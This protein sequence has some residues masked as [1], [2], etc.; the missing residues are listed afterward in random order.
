MKKKKWEKPKL[1]IL[2]RGKPEERVLIACKAGVLGGLSANAVGC[3]VGYPSCV[4]CVVRF[5]SPSPR[6]LVF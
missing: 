5:S 6:S 4:L 1:I 2:T 3:F